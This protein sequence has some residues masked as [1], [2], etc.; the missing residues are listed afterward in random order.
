MQGIGHRFFG[1]AQKS[2]KF[3]VGYGMYVRSVCKVRLIADQWQITLVL[4]QLF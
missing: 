3:N 1:A 4:E 2:D